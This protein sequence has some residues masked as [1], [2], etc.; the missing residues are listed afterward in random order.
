MPHQMQRVS[1]LEELSA[2]FDS[3]EKILLKKYSVMHSCHNNN[4]NSISGK[5]NKNGSLLPPQSH[6]A[7]YSNQT[8]A[9]NTPDCNTQLKGHLKVEGS[10]RK[11]SFLLKQHSTCHVP[12]PLPFDPHQL[13]TETS[14]MKLPNL[15]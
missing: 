1:I 5:K 6:T 8:A 13:M 10:G 11:T 9:Y 3:S 12:P 2:R 7:Y 14:Q 4:T 15:S